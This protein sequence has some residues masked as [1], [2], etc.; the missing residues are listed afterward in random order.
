MIDGVVPDTTE[1]RRRVQTMLEAHW[2]PEGY[3]AP[4]DR[5]YPWQWLWDSC[6]TAIGLS[7]CDPHRAADEL[8]AL[9]RGQCANGMVPHM[10][11]VEG[12]KGLG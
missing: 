11:F 8:R 7:R 12:L 3:A 4:N 6:F 1:L 5:V 10:I 2:V 9:F